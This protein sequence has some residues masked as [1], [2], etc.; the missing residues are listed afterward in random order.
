MLRKIVETKRLEVERLKATTS[1]PRLLEQAKEASAPRGFIRSLVTSSRPVSV[2]AEVK[3]ASPSKGLIRPEF[4]PVAIA[5]AYAAAEVEAISVLTDETYFQGSLT[6][7]QQIRQTVDQPLLRKDFLIDEWQI[8]EARAYGADCVLLIAAILEPA[9]LQALYQA[10]ESLGLDV[11]IEVHQEEELD[12]V[13]SCVKPKLLGINNRD[14]R[15]FHTDLRT[16][17]KLISEIPKEIA[18][19]SESGISSTKDIDFLQTVGARCVLVGEHF[20]R[21]SNIGQAVLD[22]VGPKTAD[23]VVSN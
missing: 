9:R 4:D 17:A 1:L 19:V 8:A 10:A 11:L 5:Q 20:M 15:T 16:T 12:S 13:L 14:L 23:T 2:I 3:K 21:Q 18:V 22:L 6:Y 7:L